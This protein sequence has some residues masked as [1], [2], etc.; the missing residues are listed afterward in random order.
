MEF[1]E[2]SKREEEGGAECLC[3]LVLTME[4]EAFE[5]NNG[6]VPAA[7]EFEPAGYLLDWVLSFFFSLF[8]GFT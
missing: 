6:G 2:E 7:A 3:L 8:S 4:L 1:E 5:D